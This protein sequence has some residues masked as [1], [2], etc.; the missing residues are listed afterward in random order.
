M[1]KFK[2]AACCYKLCLLVHLL[3]V[4]LPAVL[5]QRARLSQEVVSVDAN[6]YDVALLDEASGLFEIALQC[7]QEKQLV[8]AVRG[9]RGRDP[10]DGDRLC[11]GDG[12]ST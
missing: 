9:E 10:S 4:H 8:G 5:I 11:D 6:R 3:H 2:V 7:L 1:S 12:R